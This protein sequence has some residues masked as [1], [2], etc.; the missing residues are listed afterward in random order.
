MHAANLVIITGVSGSGKSTALNA[1][2]DLGYFC[3]GNLPTPLLLGFV[4]YLMDLPVL[5]AG[6]SNEAESA[7][8]HE[9][10]LTYQQRNF[11][12]LIDVRDKISAPLISEANEKLTASGIQV[13]LLYFDCQDEVLLRRFRET[14]RPHPLLVSGRYD[15]TISEVVSRER[16]ML[17]PLRGMA[18]QIFDT[19]HY[20]IHDLRKVIED[21]AHSERKLEIVVS[22]FGFKFGIP[23]DADL[24]AD[25]RFLPNPHFVEH[26]RDKTG[27]SK[28]V[29]DYVFSTLEAEEFLR[30]YTELLKFLIPK[31]REEG[32]RYLNVAIGCTGGRHRSVAI[33]A[34]LARTVR[35]SDLK[36]SLR[37][38]DMQRS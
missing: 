32:K 22:S 21:Y 3:V 2:E 4:D 8:N 38:R 26:M 13:K 29:R 27:E 20:T 24:V 16:A 19:S 25:V 1:F 11:A 17:S 6:R 23:H 12:L 10:L 18:S 30:R 34:E 14:R 15:E 37:H 36:V 31:Y 33:A 35:Q 9:R 7:A 5:V 28:E